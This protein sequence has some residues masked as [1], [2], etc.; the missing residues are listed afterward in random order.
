MANGKVLI[1][2][3][4]PDIGGLL[5][6]RLKRAGYE[7]AFAADAVTALTVARKERPDVILLDLGLPGGDG[8]LVMERLKALAPLA[9]VPVIVVSPRDP[10]VTAGPAL[11]AGAFAFVPKPLDVDALLAHVRRAL[12]G[13]DAENS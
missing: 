11:G 3:D 13:G 5:A 12:R 9:H 10:A 4:D 6:V 7:T 8:L 2:E 1:V